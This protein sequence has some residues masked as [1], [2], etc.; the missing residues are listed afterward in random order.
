V[1]EKGILFVALGA[2]AVVISL[3]VG[4][5]TG[6]SLYTLLV[7]VLLAGSVLALWFYLRLRADREAPPALRRLPPSDVTEP[8]PSRVT[9]GPVLLETATPD[10]R[11]AF[12]AT[13]LWRPCRTE[14]SPAA[15]IRRMPSHP[16][17][18]PAEPTPALR[19]AESESVPSAPGP[20]AAAESE[21]AEPTPAPGAAGSESAEPTA[22]PRTADAPEPAEPIPAEAALAPH[23]SIT[24]A[25]EPGSPAA[26]APVGHAP[27]GQDEEQP[28][29]DT[30]GRW[31]ADLGALATAAAAASA[32]E[33]V[34]S[35]AAVDA[36]TT[37]Q[38]LAA[39]LG[40]PRTDSSGTVRW[41]AQDVDLQPADLD[42][43]DRLRTLSQLRKQV[44]IW[45]QEREHELNVR[46]YLG[47]DVLT[48]TGSALVWWLARHLDDVHG[49]IGMIGDLSKLSAVSQD[50]EYPG[51][52]G[53]APVAP[54]PT[55]VGSNGG[56]DIG[57]DVAATVDLL[58]RL[59]PG[60]EDER[61]MFARDL[62]MIAERSGRIDYARRVRR[63]FGVPDLTGSP[64]RPTGDG[65]PED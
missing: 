49:A 40:W 28:N 4:F 27:S 43:A 10:F 65:Q 52:A 15:P 14:Q 5:V 62:A 12:S 8:S 18:D 37:K 51:R 48:T 6:W 9:V 54:P 64:P 41:C 59:F 26:E 19:G 63:M 53:G 56:R 20:P 16:E 3:L 47:E 35:S 34:L 30:G 57:S 38:R 2:A 44:Q 21:P 24:E 42:D 60:S 13:V 45:Q 11:L 33:I 32:A 1:N 55:F 17:R 29:G 25:S 31:H 39:E 46:R 61:M 7:A 23:S 58:E 36:G 50:R 22:A